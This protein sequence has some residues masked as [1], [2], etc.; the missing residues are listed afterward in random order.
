MG[1]G[2][3]TLLHVEEHFLRDLA[4]ASLVLS[5]VLIPL[6][7]DR[8]IGIGAALWVDEERVALGVILA[9][10]EV[11]RNVNLAT[12]SRATFADRDRLGDDVG[13]RVVRGVNHFRTGVLVLAVIREGD[14]NDLSTSALSFHDDTWVFHGET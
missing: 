7:G 9:A 6:H 11:L 13:S 10:L 4:H 14:G 2:E 1:F 3:A 5:D 12:V 8:R